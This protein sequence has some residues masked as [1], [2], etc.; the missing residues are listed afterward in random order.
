MESREDALKVAKD[1]A[2]GFFVMAA[3]QGCVGF[4]L[5]PSMLVDAAVIAILA[6]ILR[7]KH[8]RVA[9]ILLLLLS[10]LLVVTTT[11]V[12]L[13]ISKTGG[14]NIFLA[15]IVLWCAIRSVQATFLLH[16]RFKELPVPV[17]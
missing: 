17:E 12:K 3:I 5:A 1:C 11:L 7:F 8:S 4:F 9:A 10:L 14:S 6:A 16:G 13:G 2:N 15:V